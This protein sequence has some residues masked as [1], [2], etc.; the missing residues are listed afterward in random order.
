M[1]FK[2]KEHYATRECQDIT[3][4]PE[5]FC[6][7]SGTVASCHSQTSAFMHCYYVAVNRTIT[8]HPQKVKQ[9]YRKSLFALPALPASLPSF[10]GTSCQFQRPAPKRRCS[11]H[12]NYRNRG[13]SL[14]IPHGKAVSSQYGAPSN[15]TL[16]GVFQ[17]FV[18][19]QIVC[20]R[21]T[22]RQPSEQEGTAI[23]HSY[24]GIWN[25]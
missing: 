2:R 15:M 16:V 12:P 25:E 20:V 3:N 5:L 4:L 11:R 6:S 8:S 9:S 19:F 17:G 18:S 7:I 10:A 14:H 24:Q 13:G 1:V 23:C 21:A 22:R